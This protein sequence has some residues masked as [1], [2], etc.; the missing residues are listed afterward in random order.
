MPLCSYFFHCLASQW[1]HHAVLCKMVLEWYKKFVWQWE[2]VERHSGGSMRWIPT[3]FFLLPGL[4]LLF[5]PVPTWVTLDFCCSNL[6]SEYFY[7]GLLP[8]G[9]IEVAFLLPFGKKEQAGT[10]Y[11]YVYVVRLDKAETK[12]KLHL[13]K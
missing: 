6:I 11:T 12:P 2:Q 9:W 10:E 3:L 5:P 7:K 13:S 1:C 4:F 8:W